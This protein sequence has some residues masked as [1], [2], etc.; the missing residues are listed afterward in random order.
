[1]KVDKIKLYILEIL[2]LTILVLAFF[3]LNTNIR[4]TLAIFL[5]I[6][7]IVLGL[8]VKK[9]ERLFIYKK[10]VALLGIGFAAIYLGVFYFSGLYFGYYPVEVKFGVWSIGH[11][12]IPTTIIIISSE[13]IRY[14][15]VSQKD[16]FSD[17]VAFISMTLVDVIVYTQVYD[18]SRLNDFL[19][20]FCFIIISSISC[21]LLYNYMSKRYGYKP[22][23]YYRLGTSLYSYI[24]PIIPNVL[25][26]F[27]AIFRMVY[28]YIIYR[29]L[30]Y[31]YSPKVE[32]SE[33]K[34]KNRRILGNVIVTAV[35]VVI[36]MLISCQ[37]KYGVMVIGSGSMAGT[38]D[39]GDVILFE[40]Y[41]DQMIKEGDI[42]IFNHDRRQVI[43][44]VVK[45]EVVNSQYRYYTKGDANAKKDD[46][47]I[48]DENIVG[49]SQA[50]IKYIGYPTLW[51]H[52][53][54][55]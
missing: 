13:F 5:I 42:I 24:I 32:A 44:R 36:V 16:K 49:I 30:E 41:E 45:I 28:P 17:I 25:I 7:A 39:K 52:D 6:Y 10:Q 14:V 4:S 40:K 51:V 38:M 20:V 33:V 34:G 46:W 27:R 1:M 35:M 2:L 48:T 23:I 22:I 15:L 31:T 54:F 12:I 19:L 9:R 55:N 47:Y 43:H 8:S 11:L 50:R 26:F 53:I 3:K 29:I 21:N 18:I 37:F